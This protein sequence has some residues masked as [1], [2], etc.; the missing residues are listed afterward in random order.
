MAVYVQVGAGAGDLDYSAGFRDGFTALI[1]STNL[2]PEDRIIVVEA[3]KFNIPTLKEC[4]SDY[5][6]VE[7]HPVAIASGLISDET[8]LNFYYAEDDGPFFQ[9]ASLKEDHVRAFFPKGNILNFEVKCFSINYFLKNVI[10]ESS[11]EI[12]ALDIE[13]LDIEVLKEL[14]LDSFEIHQIS[15]ERSHDTEQYAVVC[16]KLKAYG[17]VK[18]GSGMDPHNSDVLWV[19]PMNY[20]EMV[21]MSVRNLRHF[22]WEVQ[23]PLRHQIKSLLKYRRVP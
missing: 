14:D 5:R 15:F 1:K 10:G 18:A 3:N 20:W 12:L 8:K 21:M 13:G 6:Q 22:A 19:K 17:Y 2:N 11:F 4:W 7:I 9:I 16:K 23:I